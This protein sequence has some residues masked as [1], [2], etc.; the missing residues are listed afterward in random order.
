[1]DRDHDHRHGPPIEE[2][3]TEEQPTAPWIPDDPAPDRGLEPGAMVDHFRVIRL[4]GRGGMGAVYLARDTRL[5]RKVALKVIRPARMGSPDAARRFLIE[6]RATA[7]FNHPNIVTIYAVGE[8]GGSPYVALEY[9]EGETLR[10]RFDGERVPLREALRLGIAVAGAL[11]EAHAHGILHRDLKAENVVIS[12]DGRPR[13]LDFG[14]AKIVSPGP[15]AASASET[16]D[17]GTLDSEGLGDALQTDGEHLCGTPATMAPEQWAGGELSGA[18]DVWAL[19][20]LL[21]ELVAGRRPY[22]DM[23]ATLTTLAWTLSQP[24]PVPLDPVIAETSPELARLLARC[25][26]KNPGA[27]PDAPE[28]VTALQDMVQP[29]RPRFDEERSPFRGLQ[30]F[31]ERHAGVFFGR[32]AEIAAFLER[33]R[34]EPVLPVVGPSG[35][36][37]SSFVLAGVVPRL[38]ELGPWVLLTLRPGP[39]PFVALA[40]RLLQGE[41]TVRTGGSEPAGSVTAGRA[42]GGLDAPTW[43]A[44]RWG[45][46]PAPRETARADAPPSHTATGDPADDGTAAEAPSSGHAT[47]GEEA[48][49]ATFSGPG[50]DAAALADRLAATPTLLGLELQ[51][52]AE[53]EGARVLLV[54]DQV[55]ELF[56]L[57]ES[58]ALRERFMRAI[59]VA[60]DDAEGPIRVV[61][62]LRDDFLGRLALGPEVREALGRVT[63]IRTPGP[64]ALVDILRRP[65]EVVGYDYDD[66]AVVDE[67]I[68]E[69]R[70]EPAALPLLQFAA[71]TLWERRDKGRKVLRRATYE[72]VGGVAGALAE[73]ADGVLQGMDHRQERLAR[74]ILL[75]LVT[76]AGTR[77]VLTT[78][79]VLEGLDDGAADVLARLTGSRLVSVRKS[80]RDRSGELELVHES[81]V[82]TWRQLAQWID[83]SREDLVFLDEIGQAAEL[84]VKRG[85]RDDEVWTGDALAE[86]R[87]ILSRTSTR[88]PEDVTVFLEACL[89]HERH[90]ARRKRA[91]AL[92]GVGLLAL[93]ALGSLLFSVA[94]ADREREAQR[95]RVDAEARQADA[96]RE[97]ARAAL[98]RGDLLEARAKLRSSL[99]IEDSPLA[100][101]LWR[102]AALQPLVWTAELGA[103]TN[104]VAFSPDGRLLA[105]GSGDAT[106]YVFDTPSRQVRFLRGH[107][108]Q[109]YA[110]AFSPDGATLASADWS[111]VILLWD[112]A[113]GRAR[114][115]SGHVGAINYMAFA[116]DGAHLATGGADGTVR[117]WDTIAASPPVVLPSHEGEAYGVAYSGDGA[118]LAS[119]GADRRII[120][121]DA[122]SHEVLR[123]ITG[124]GDTVADIA[125][126]PSGDR[127]ASASLDGAVRIWD[128]GTGAL[129]ETLDSGNDKT[130]DVAFAPD[131]HHVL[132]GRWNGDVELWALGGGGRRVIGRHGSNVYTVAVSPDG[133]FAASGGTNREVR[134]WTTTPSV[135]EV[136]ERGHAGAVIAMTFDATGG[137]IVSGGGDHRI[138]TW[139]VLTGAQTDT[140]IEEGFSPF[141]MASS[142][143]GR[144][145]A[146]TDHANG[147]LW[148]WDLDAGTPPRVALSHH[149][150]IRDVAFDAASRRIVTVGLGGEGHVWDAVTWS[151]RPL[152]TLEPATATLL[153]VDF[154]PDGS[155]VA[156]AGNDGLI[157]IYDAGTGARR[158]I[159]S[160]HERPARDVA[161]SPDGSRLASVGDDGAVLLW[162]L[163]RGTSRTIGH[164]QARIYDVAFHPDGSLVATAGSDRTALMWPLDGSPPRQ[165]RGHGAE[166]NHVDIDPTGRALATC[167]DDGT[168]RLWDAHTGAAVWRAPLLT[169]DPPWL[170]THRGWTPMDPTA[171][172]APPSGA[173]ADAAAERARW[174]AR[175]GDQLCLVTHDDVLEQWD[176]S[177]D[178]LLLTAAV[179]GVMQV[180][181]LGRGCVTRTGTGSTILHQRSGVVQELTSHGVTMAADGDGLL[182]ASPDAIT[183]FDA[184]GRRVHTRE[185]R[186]GVTVVAR[187]HGRLALGF[188]DGNVELVP[189]E[190]D[191]P[192]APSPAATPLQDVPSSPV[193]AIAAGPAQTVIVGHADG[194]VGIWD[195]ASGARL[196]GVDLHGPV[197]HLLL[198]GGHL[199]AATDIG[200]H[201]VMDLGV[202]T[203]D[204][205]DLLRSVW[206]QVPVVWASGKA[207]PQPPDPDHRCA[208]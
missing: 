45:G 168:V 167:S 25:L 37:K 30:P 123:E 190:A 159:L 109:I 80:H 100:R 3:P 7:R 115:L 92:A 57:V 138:H 108:D 176:L 35:A 172:S 182:V 173:W 29:D 58:E 202:L 48:R 143:D 169:G 53:R 187:P 147:D 23:E 75:R 20:V 65:L 118:L 11:V 200:D 5:G 178:E 113:T 26:D 105:A 77:R 2:T 84:W 163:E 24:D 14:L 94:L 1:M 135:P 120:V 61:F 16:H 137:Q 141:S 64:E 131:G 72:A 111:G 70:G 97:G 33:L 60:A 88:V 157:R 189:P 36:G 171:D 66:P 199:I 9:L 183:A 34:D 146:A 201:E 174:A 196:D 107:E 43:P 194:S 185:G 52:L 47:D 205:C 19:G 139:D 41:T 127:L 130:W 106:I 31:G 114:R 148:L 28:V 12:R 96:Q 18:T 99:E 32:D 22:H 136:P 144:W 40:T 158:R 170:L 175:A 90:L 112:M 51:T 198:A 164:R 110:M 153:G 142:P 49:Q 104:D 44:V 76:P 98:A 151:P 93:V 8:V 206:D 193:T 161:F 149:S 165:L 116:P 208:R 140:V 154:S 69:V 83:E 150:I 145:L 21:H 180:L 134:L 179:P 46:H 155:T 133:R 204:Y 160:G 207:V 103:T 121:R 101:S 39:D 55:E 73:H 74:E 56:S 124:H 87:R 27:R 181:A 128:V 17:P 122:V 10:Q 177:A 86:A 156:A 129:L 81:L 117:I 191:A 50:E 67:M 91:L 188:G 95:A 6:A 152:A 63:V 186:A 54:V 203:M 162:D 13:V 15:A 38:R 132:V 42:T 82:R 166:V 79:R 89:R 184:E 192:P 85:R 78:T 68:A 119:G 4:I 126:S 197:T 71:Q 102:E 125:F 59:C 195:T 62:T